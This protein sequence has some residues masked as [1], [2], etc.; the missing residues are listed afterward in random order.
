MLSILWIAPFLMASQGSGA[1]AR[2]LGKIPNAFV[3]NRGQTDPAVRFYA[4]G[5]GLTAFLTSEAIALRLCGSG[6]G[7]ANLFL[8]FEGADPGTEVQGIGELPGRHNFYLGSDPEG[9]VLGALGFRA[10]RYRS[11]YSG[12]GLEVY[13]RDGYLEYDLVL[14][15]GADLSKVCVRVEGAQELC[16]D[17]D[18]A[19]S[20]ETAAGTLRQEAPFAY[21]VENS[22]ERVPVA[23]RVRLL[24]EDRFGFEAPEWKGEGRLRLDPVVSFSTYLG[25]SGDDEGNGVAVDGSGH[26]W[27]TGTTISFDFPASPGAFQGANAGGMDAFVSKLNGTGA[28]LLVST[29]LGGPADDEGLAVALD[30]SGNAYVTGIA[31]GGFPTTPGAFLT[32]GWGTFVTKLD[33]AGA[34]VFSTYLGSAYGNAIAVDGSGAAYVTGFTSPLNLVTTLGAFQTQS[35]DVGLYSPYCSFCS[36]DA[37]VTKLDPTGGALQYSTYLSGGWGDSAEGIAL[38]QDGSAYVVGQTF[39]SDFP[40]TS[41]AYDKTWNGIP[42]S[43]NNYCY[44]SCNFVPLSGN[45]FFAKI[46]PSGSALSY[47][48]HYGTGG[49][50][51]FPGG[52]WGDGIAVD[53]SGKAT[54]TGGTGFGSIPLS[55]GAYSASGPG[56]VAKFDPSL[57]GARSLIFS[58]AITKGIG[59]AIDLDSSG[60]PYVVEG[61][62]LTHL[63]S[64]GTALVAQTDLGTSGQAIDVD[65]CGAAVVAGLNSGTLSASSWAFQPNFA[66]GP[67]DAFVVKV[68]PSAEEYGPS[69]AGSGGFVPALA[70]SGCA[71]VGG[72]VNLAVTDGLGGAVGA[73]FF[74]TSGPASIPALGGKLL[75]APPI[76]WVKVTLGGAA[77]TAGAGSLSVP[78]NI[79][80]D[81]AF[82]GLMLN[83]QFMFLDPGALFGVSQTNGVQITID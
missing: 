27:V 50:I 52:T 71:K 5:T 48:T 32:S 41:N 79:P 37:Y 46:D 51:W 76:K 56:F 59:E 33:P 2:D 53:G 28:E 81:P 13:L 25:G 78:I 30:P 6:Q 15:P 68:G 26:I 3:E 49:S 21:R 10:I 54:I 20:I 44:I 43:W 23:C 55:P 60:E 75:V 14:E 36:G 22:D 58:T 16:L 38:S 31:S 9:W 17:E 64:T 29:Y 35:V 7:G 19:L 42:G 61:N 8:R 65:A 47:S 63:N 66:G 77:G 73:L 24:E 1:V 12:I 74:G 4:R 34:V 62:F 11:L 67:N 70:A 40:T 69:L 72:T 45:V 80:P 18:G 57:S 83:L 82:S 39:S